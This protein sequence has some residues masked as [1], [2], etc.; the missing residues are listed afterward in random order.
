MKQTLTFAAKCLVAIMLFMWSIWAGASV[1]EKFLSDSDTILNAEVSE[2]S[3]EEDSLN[4]AKFQQAEYDMLCLVAHFEGV[5]VN[6]YWDP[7]GRIWTIG[8]GNTV[9]PNGT[10]VKY[11]DRIKD[12]DE[13]FEYFKAHVEAY[14]WPDMQKYLPMSDMTVQEIAALGSLFYNCG[15]G[16]LR[17]KDGSPTYLADVIYSCY[18][19]ATHPGSVELI[20]NGDTSVVYT[21]DSKKAFEH[22]K[23]ELIRL[24]NQKV[25]AK[26][27]KLDVLVKRRLLEQKIFFGE[28]IMDNKGEFALENS[29]NFAEQPLGAAYSIPIRDF[30]DVTLVCDSINNCPYGRNLQD[31]IEYAFAHPVKRSSATYRKKTTTRRR[32]RR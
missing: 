3:A 16:I 7:H 25:Y 26:G 22:S 5:K 12:K 29:V 31:S 14:I 9:R 19:F 30:N 28:I 4:F 6:A 24:M 2:L 21:V 13:L 20:A 27:K 11:G 23:S 18:A 1:T 32:I 8:I 15:S 10:K 17:N